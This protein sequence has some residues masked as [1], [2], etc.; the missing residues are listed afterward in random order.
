M[1]YQE[2]FNLEPGSL[3]KISSELF[4]WST[5]DWDGI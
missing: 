3:V 1:N 2:L 4:L 5:R